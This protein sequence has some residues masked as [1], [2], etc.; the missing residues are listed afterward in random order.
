MGT[1][2]IIYLV[3][4]GAIFLLAIFVVL[5]WRVKRSANKVVRTLR[6]NGATN[7]KHAISVELLK[8]RPRSMF[9]LRPKDF[10]KEGLDLLLK[11]GIVQLT[12]EGKLFLVEERLFKSKLSKSGSEYYR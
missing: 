6:E 9:T 5:P 8:I 10:K 7:A 11:T 1:V 4:M 2:D 3:S 12:E